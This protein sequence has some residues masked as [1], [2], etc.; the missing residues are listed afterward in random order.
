M[1]VFQPEVLGLIVARGAAGAVADITAGLFGIGGGFV[2][3]PA[4]LAVFPL[5]SEAGSELIYVAI[6]TS[7]ASIIVSSARAVQA[8]Q[9]RGAVD[10]GVLKDWSIWLVL[11]VCVGLYIAAVTDGRRLFVVFAIGVL[12]YSLYFLFPDFFRRSVPTLSMPK[13]VARASLASVLGGFSALL[14]IG[15]GTVTVIT[16]V[17]CNRPVHQAVAT[18]AG[19]GFIIAL[20]GTVGF[21]FLGLGVEGLPFGSIGYINVPAL[22]AISAVSVI[23]APIGANWAHSLDELK[24]KRLFGCYL[25]FVAVT[26]F[27]KATTI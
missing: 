19:V 8:H 10:F 6:G 25:V 9:R 24:L 7:L 11:G 2:V 26:M 27:Y 13:G 14:G 18:A 20:P 5:F 4:L 15:G 3:V 22:L 21:L 12:G 17:M 23:T 1:D 16:M